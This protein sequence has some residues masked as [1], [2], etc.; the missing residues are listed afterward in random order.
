MVLAGT[1]IF[2]QTVFAQAETVQNISGTEQ[3][4]A[5]VKT[6]DSLIEGAENENMSTSAT[7]EISVQNAD[8]KSV[9]E[10]IM[11]M[12]YS[13]RS[14]M[15]EDSFRS[16]DRVDVA[17]E[18][19]CTAELSEESANLINVT[20]K[21]AG[22]TTFVISYTDGWGKKQEKTVKV[23]VR[24]QLPE[25]GVVIPDEGLRNQLMDTQV[26]TSN[27]YQYFSEDGYVSK[28]EMESLEDIYIRDN[29]KSLQG[30]EYAVNLTSLRA[31][32]NL[33]NADMEIIKKLSK[34]E[35][36]TIDSSNSLSNVKG[37]LGLSSL[38]ELNLYACNNL[39]DITGI[40][41]LKNL[42]K[43]SVS[44]CWNLTSINSEI[45]FLA[46]I[47]ADVSGTGVS[48]AELRDLLSVK[49]K[50]AVKG[51][52]VDLQKCG[53]YSMSDNTLD[54]PNGLFTVKDGKLI[55]Q[56]MG[57]T[58]FKIT[59]D[60]QQYEITA[61]VNGATDEELKLGDPYSVELKALKDNQSGKSV[62]LTSNGD[63]WNTY[64]E[65]KRENT[66][67]KE[68]ISEW[69]YSSHDTIV[70][71]YLTNNG[72]LYYEGTKVADNVKAY[73]GRY[74]LTNAGVLT[75]IY[76]KQSISMDHVVAFHDETNTTYG[77]GTYALKTDG[78]VWFRSEGSKEEPG[79]DFSK[80][81][82]GIGEVSAT[83]TVQYGS[84]GVFYI[85]KADGTLWN[86]KENKKISDDVAEVSERYYTKKDGKSYHYVTGEEITENEKP[87]YKY[88]QDGNC[89]VGDNH[90]NLGKI[91]IKD[92]QNDYPYIYYITDNGDLYSI[93]DSSGEQPEKMLENAAE[94][95]GSYYNWVDHQSYEIVKMSDGT[96]YALRLGS[97]SQD[98]KLRTTGGDSVLY[99]NVS[100]DE[101]RIE[102]NGV[103]VLD[104]VKE[105][106]DMTNNII[107]EDGT[108][109]LIKDGIPTK[110]LDLSKTSENPIPTP[111]P[112]PTPSHTD[113]LSNTLENGNLYYYKDGKIAT[114]VTTVA[115]NA[116]GWYYVNKGKV[117]FSYTGFATNSNGSWY[118]EKGQVTFKKTSVLEDT[119]GALG[120]VGAWY[121]VKGSQVQKVTTVAPNENGWWRI[122]NGKVDFKCNSVES[123]ENGWWYIRNGKVDFNYT[124]VAQNAGGWWRIVKGQV[125]F[126]C[127]SV[128]S[129]ANGW[130]YIRGGKVN[131]GYTGVAQNA[132]GWW[133]I[134]N[135]Q[136]DFHCNSVES[137]EN[138]WWYIRG[139]KVNFEYTGVA[140]N[141]N[142]W[143]RIVN[144]QVD[145]HCNSV[146][147]NENGWWYIRG[148]KVDFG[149]TGIASNAN[150]R[151]YIRNG[152]VDFSRNGQVSVGGR[153]YRVVNGKVQ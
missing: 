60:G 2:G 1:M 67:V 24:E 41:K 97:L 95:S 153:T 63:L 106:Y 42:E 40:S 71:E 77:E 72:E 31:G 76:S 26:W 102:R 57:T 35:K 19:I 75:D 3:A 103:I 100:T 122:V 89:Y 135:G 8:Q 124:G 111:D 125:D 62:I 69:V 15:F 49:L 146:E 38:K 53:F 18:N 98:I 55:A 132:N 83:D 94:F 47:S 123:N 92:I 48:G 116:S 27:G 28:S 30:L 143:W 79:S 32:S 39:T 7:E 16:L 10:L 66:N 33:T 82:N 13:S 134:V 43:L 21:K 12:D 17:D 147:S 108:V 20:A 87:D 22:E 133:R 58:T 51:D 117:D 64:P 44:G 50:G 114:D 142:G 130:W 59:K 119:T 151:W 101:N 37:L 131:F 45:E 96:G 104:H 138:G 11:Y 86:V 139:G 80:V 73:S 149:Y 150:G 120:E 70:T 113:G 129:N 140:Q 36:L 84:D 148:G 107:R 127:N 85:L 90:I 6:E 65:V 99:K 4:E 5:D 25:D 88:D 152:Q 54:D 141:A 144:G 109:W 136:V 14:Y 23:V 81:M 46:S 61:S 121:Y 105:V 91:V 126:N 137:N 93:R 34:L 74:V 56:K 78:S 9:E 52:A 68:Y 110:V 115:Q 112:T 118:I 145:F 128:E 29:V